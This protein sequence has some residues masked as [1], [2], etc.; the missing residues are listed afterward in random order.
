MDDVLDCT[1]ELRYALVFDA[2]RFKVTFVPPGVEAKPDL[3][4]SRD[5]NPAYVEVR[6]IG[7]ISGP[8]LC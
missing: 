4:V 1:I 3:L 8:C 7:E 5:D 2:R 6:R